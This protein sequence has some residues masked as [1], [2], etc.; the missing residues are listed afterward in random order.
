MNLFGLL[1]KS[2]WRRLLLAMAAST[3]SGLSIAGLLALINASLARL[4]AP[5]MTLALGFA[6]LCLLVLS[7]RV[8]AATLLVHLSQQSLG[9]LRAHLSRQILAAPLPR[10]EQLGSHRLLAALT[11]DVH[12]VAE[13]FD[14][15]PVLCMNLALIAGCLVY[16]GWLSPGLLAATLSLL[17]LGILG[18][19]RAQR[20]ALPALER[21]RAAGDELQRHFR[22]LTDGAKELKLNAGRR[23]GFLH[24]ALAETLEALRRHF[25]E[26]MTTL[27]RAEAWGS[28]LFLML[29]G[30]FLFGAGALW[31]QDLAVMTGYV[32]VLLYLRGPLEGLIANLPDISRARIALSRI[33]ALRLDLEGQGERTPAVAGSFTSLEGLE[34]IGVSHRYRREGED[35]PFMLG[36]LH[37]ALRPGEIVFLVGGNGSGKTTL[38]KLLLG[39]YTPESG[40]I[41]VNGVSI[42]DDNREAYRQLFSVVFADFYLFDTLPRP[43]GAP[44]SRVQD[45]LRRLQ[46]SH[47]LRIEDGRFSTTA[48]S[49]GQRKRLALLNGYLEDR[50]VYVFDEWAADQDP[51]FKRVFYT[52]LLPEL[53][54]RG[55]AVLAITHDDHYFELADRCL[56][57]DEGQLTE[58][59]VPARTSGRSAMSAA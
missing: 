57:L 30:L 38:A 40:S 10:L 34:L 43:S 16:M 36:P 25:V 59:P 51:A 26:G 29:V 41:R 14:R 18:F 28:L 39:L 24:G 17:A 54:A 48:L 35:K 6:G 11:E 49:Q 27:A 3:V 56:K 31:P 19:R 21:S 52:E 5:S 58:L 23:E 4:A 7:A 33:E 32:L 9:T 15:L 37:L 45:Y 42:T 12:A 2:S 44:A 46:L 1:L 53:R 20:H 50:P 13:I 47:K 8:L 22:A 55:K